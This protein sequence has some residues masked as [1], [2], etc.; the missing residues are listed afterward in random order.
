LAR[1]AFGKGFDTEGTE[2]RRGHGGSRKVK[3]FHRESA[4]ERE[5]TKQAT[6]R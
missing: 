5:N 2:G 3:V 6:A 4:K 1:G